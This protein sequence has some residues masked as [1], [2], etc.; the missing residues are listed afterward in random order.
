MQNF[1]KEIYLLVTAHFTLKWVTGIVLAVLSFFFDLLLAKVFLILL[2]LTFIDCVL[3][4]YRA[5]LDKRAVTSKVM[6]AYGWRFFGYITAS[7]VMFMV[8][9]S[10]PHLPYITVLVGYLDDIALGFFI[11]QEA[12]SVIEHLNELGVPMPAGLFANLRKIKDRLDDPTDTYKASI[13]K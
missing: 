12:T 5:V 1:M 2:I 9:Q 7:S 11:V 10:F 6:R 4:Y 3:G 13:K 8:S